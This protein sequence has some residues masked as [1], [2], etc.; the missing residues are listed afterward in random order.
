MHTA[1][2]NNFSSSKR[3]VKIT[4]PN[5]GPTEKRYNT[6]SKHS[7][8]N[9]HPI[10]IN[11]SFNYPWLYEIPNLQTTTSEVIRRSNT[12][13]VNFMSYG[14]VYSGTNTAFVFNVDL[15]FQIHFP[16]LSFVLDVAKAA[17][18]QEPVN[19]TTL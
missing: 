9:K 8:E 10:L 14:Y 15:L 19:F 6:L 17:F 16:H 12:T 13:L 4:M 7:R 11:K 3:T 2:R 18:L 1:V 5:S